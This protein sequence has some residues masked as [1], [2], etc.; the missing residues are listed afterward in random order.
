MVIKKSVAIKAIQEE[1]I[2]EPSNW[3]KTGGSGLLEDA[4]LDKLMSCAVCAVGSVLRANCFVKSGKYKTI[5][6]DGIF[7]MCQ[8]TFSSG[9]YHDYFHKDPKNYLGNLS[10]LFEY[11]AAYG[12]PNSKEMRDLL[13]DYIDKNWPDEFEVAV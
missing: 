8:G 3:F 12:D 1:P 7:D 4:S 11:Q 2:L 10:M 9:A 6:N 5:G 13:V